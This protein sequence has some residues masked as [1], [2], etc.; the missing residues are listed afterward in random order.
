MAVALLAGLFGVSFIRSIWSTYERM[1][2]IV[3]LAHWLAFAVVLVSTLRTAANWRTLL[4]VNLAVS[5][6][7]ALLG[8]GKLIGAAGRLHST[9]SSRTPGSS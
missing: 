6:F 1:Q 3:D 5:L 2:G 8:A 4:N 7:L 9:S